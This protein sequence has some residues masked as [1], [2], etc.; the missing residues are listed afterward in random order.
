MAKVSMILLSASLVSASAVLAQEPLPLTEGVVRDVKAGATHSFT[1]QLNAGDYVAGFVDQRGIVV[2]ATAFL[3]DGSKVRTFNGPPSGKRQFAIVAETAGAYRLDLW[4]PAIKEVEARGGRQNESGSYEL[5]VTEKLSADERFNA[6][7]P[8]KLSSPAIDALRD[9]VAA[10]W[11][12][13]DDRYSELRTEATSSRLPRI[14]M[15]A[16]GG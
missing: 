2:V 8:A 15:F 10:V 13:R 6:A 11:R 1:M 5:K 7:P 9:A 14:E 4:A 12:V 3:P 16:M